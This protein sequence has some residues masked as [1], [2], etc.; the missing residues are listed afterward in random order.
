MINTFENIYSCFGVLSPDELEIINNN[1]TQTQYLKG[2]TIFKQGAFASHVLLVNSGLVRVYLQTGAS[3]QI[4][5]R[6]AKQ[7]DY[8]AFSAIFGENIFRYS[9]VAVKDTAICMIEK[10]ALKQILLQNPRF[11][12]QITSRNFEN[13]SRYID[14][15]NNLSYKQMRGKLAS[16]ILYLSSEEFE[17]ENVFNYLTRQNIADFASITI[18][19]AVKFIKEFEKEGIIST[20]GKD[21][22]IRNKNL[23]SE[24]NKKG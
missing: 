7:G 3:K 22:F 9:A 23:L 2:E 4:S 8:M 24:I 10:A 6:L 12:M 18:E 1:K 15:I 20:K 11:A 19:S 17:N 16:A 21:I 14:I 5:F 13:E